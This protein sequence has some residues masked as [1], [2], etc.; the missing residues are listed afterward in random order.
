MTVIDLGFCSEVRWE[1]IGF[2]EVR[3]GDTART[4]D[5]ET[6]EVIASGRVD[7]LVRLADHDRATSDVLGTVARSD[8]PT[9]ERRVIWP[10]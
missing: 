9:T 5:P 3:V 7:H 2:H 8:V 4:L 1:P 6:G 10:S